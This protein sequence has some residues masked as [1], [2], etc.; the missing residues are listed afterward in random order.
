MGLHL[1]IGV[2]LIIGASW[3][4]GGIAEDVVTGD[5]LTMLDMHIA[6]WFNMQRTPGL[7]TTMQIVT[8]LGSTAWVTVFGTV[9]ALV[10][11]WKRFWYRLL[12]L[13]LV[14]PCGMLLNSLLKIAFHRHR[15][16]EGPLLF[17]S[18]YSF[19]SGHTMAATLLYGLLAVFAVIALETWRWRVAAVLGAV[20]M[21]LLVGFSRMYLGAHYPSDVL[22][23]ATAGLAWLTLSLTAVDTLRRSRTRA[24]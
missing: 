1:T 14:L 21:I 6:E 12:A 23:A 18:G 2:L 8:I 24:P 16:S 9:T 15:P 22:G 5:P 20:V 11:C 7:M 3:L 19:P 10:L 17:F 4:F 13:V